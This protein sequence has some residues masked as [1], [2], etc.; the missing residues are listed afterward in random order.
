MNKTSSSWMYLKRKM[1][2]NIPIKFIN[3]ETRLSNLPYRYRSKIDAIYELWKKNT[4]GKQYERTPCFIISVASNKHRSSVNIGLKY[5]INYQFF[6]LMKRWMKL[7]RRIASEKKWPSIT[8]PEKSRYF[9]GLS[10]WLI[11]VRIRNRG[12]RSIMG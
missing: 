10:C 7:V 3:F 12:S 2:F 4:P 5:G 6:W 1:K 8:N 11:R 9:V